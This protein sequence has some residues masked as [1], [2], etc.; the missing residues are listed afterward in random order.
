MTE[1]RKNGWRDFRDV[2]AV[3][4]RYS[5]KRRFAS[6]VIFIAKIARTKLGRESAR[7]I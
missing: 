5:R 2:S 7:I 3:D 6:K 1:S 4:I